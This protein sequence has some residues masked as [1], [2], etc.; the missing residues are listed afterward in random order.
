M[1]F[2]L[3]VECDNEA[4]GI[5]PE[6]AQDEIARILGE[7]ATKMSD[8]RRFCSERALFDINGNRVGFLKW[9]Q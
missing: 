6:S 9:E 2:K 5:N 8:E 1:K 4:F 3:E 7:A